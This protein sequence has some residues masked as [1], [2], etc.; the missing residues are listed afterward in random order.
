[1]IRVLTLIFDITVD[2]HLYDNIEIKTP[3]KICNTYF[4]G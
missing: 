2:L 4:G 3:G 1:M